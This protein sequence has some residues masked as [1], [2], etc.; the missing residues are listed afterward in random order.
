MPDQESHIPVTPLSERIKIRLGNAIAVSPI[1]QRFAL[2][3]LIGIALIV[4]GLWQK[5][6]WLAIAGLILA[7]PVLWCYFVIM[8][9]YPLMALFEKLFTKPHEP[10]W[11]D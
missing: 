3:G 6:D 9:I 5:L 11:K 2:P 10:Y 4:M 1:M 7:A 8:L